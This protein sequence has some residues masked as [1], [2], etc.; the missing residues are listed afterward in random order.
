MS[1]L[2]LWRKNLWQEVFKDNSTSSWWTR[3]WNI[4]FCEKFKLNA[5]IQFWREK[6]WWEVFLGSSISLW[7]T[8]LWRDICTC[9]TFGLKS[10]RKELWH[11]VFHDNSVSLL[12]TRPWQK[13]CSCGMFGLKSHNKSWG[14]G[15][16]VFPYSSVSL[17]WT[18]LQQE[19]FWLCI[20]RTLS[21]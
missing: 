11:E 6:L 2:R 14:E 10:C 15:L 20:P 16:M 3:C 7:W 12:R 1:F 21:S 17:W 9:G 13:I 18:R 19:K 4:F 5:S 8:R